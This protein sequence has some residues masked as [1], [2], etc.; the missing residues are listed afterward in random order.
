[1]LELAK[2]VIV[3]VV[4]LPMAPAAGPVARVRGAAFAARR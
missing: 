3:K 2:L 4:V 1:L